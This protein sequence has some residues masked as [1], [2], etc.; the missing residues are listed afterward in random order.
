MYKASLFTSSFALFIHFSNFP[1]F[2]EIKISTRM[3]RLP[4]DAMLVI[5][6]KV[7]SSDIRHL[8]RLRATSV[9]LRGLARHNKMFR[10]L[11]RKCSLYFSDRQPCVKKLTFLEQIFRS[12]H[13]TWHF[14]LNYFDRGT[15]TWRK[16]KVIC[17]K[18]P[19]MAPTELNTS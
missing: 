15:P 9:R 12:E 7:A 11:P 5:L 3:E 6:K 16:S 10:A 18:R 19:S 13:A 4:D 17:M 14:H 1:L 2:K 8:F